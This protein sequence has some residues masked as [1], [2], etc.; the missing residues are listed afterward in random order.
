MTD[1]IP[2]VL[3]GNKS[4]LNSRRQISLEEAHGLAQQW[5]VPYIETSAKTRDNVDKV[6]KSNVTVTK[7]K[8]KTRLSD[9]GI[10]K[11]KLTIRDF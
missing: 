2:F 5:R 10:E 11:R 8:H 6:R 4:D 9:F 1:D 3:I 7:C